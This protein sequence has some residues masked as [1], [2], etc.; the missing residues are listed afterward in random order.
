[1]N[2]STKLLN[3][4]VMT[5]ADVIPVKNGAL[6]KQDGKE[7]KLEILS[8]ANV[9][10]SIIMMDPP[11]LE[12]DK[13]IPHLKRVEVRVPAYLF[14]EKSAAIKVRLSAPE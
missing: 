9:E 11:P 2:D 12:L 7:L 14:P 3:W 10:V 1:M 8:P 6:L 4:A 13:K 5:T